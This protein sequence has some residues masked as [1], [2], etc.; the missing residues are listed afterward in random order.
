MSQQLPATARETTAEQPWPV[1]TLSMKISEYVDRMSPLWVEGQV[2]QLSRRPGMSRAFITL[3]DT[4]VDMSLP[5]AIPVRALDALGSPLREGSQVVVHAKPSFWTKRGSL[6]MD[7]R[8]IR[9]VGMGELLARLEELKKML[10]AEGLFDADRKSRLPFLPRTIGVIC[11][12]DTAAERDVRAGVLR[13][14]PAATLDVRQVPVQGPETVT[15]V[16]RAVADL[17]SVPEVDVIVVTRGGGGFEDLL[18]FSNEAMLRAVAQCRTPVVSAIGHESDTPL[19]DL[20]ADVRASTPTHAAAMIV[21][22]VAEQLAGLAQAR[23]GIRSALGARVQAERRHLQ[24]LLSRPAMAD[25]GAIVRAHRIE[26]DR[27]TTR[28]RQRIHERVE[29]ESE[30]ISHVQRHLR[31]V[32]PQHTLDRGYAVVRHQDGAIVRDIVEVDAAE[33]LRVTVARGDFAV[34]P[35]IDQEGQDKP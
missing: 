27:V 18:P 28:M 5:V 4:D 19:L 12:R 24:A 22:D 20:V 1:R 25:R 6:Q 13:R 21:P 35:V 30:R 31:A 33:M 8:Q 26:L 2:V 15:A 7:A 32:S 14:W 17:D 23:R 29:R 34:R 16:S 9:H 11:G 3:R 10:R